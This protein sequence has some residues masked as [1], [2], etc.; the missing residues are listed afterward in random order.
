MIMVSKDVKIIT[1]MQV[2]SVKPVKLG[3][4]SVVT[5]Y[6]AILLI[7]FQTVLLLILTLL[8]TIADLI[9]VLNVLLDS[10]F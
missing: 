2:L 7:N 8:L 9:S 3:M 6:S 5:S 10:F 1:M 4:L